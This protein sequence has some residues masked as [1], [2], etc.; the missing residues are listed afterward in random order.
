MSQPPTE[1]SIVVG[2][3]EAAQGFDALELARVG[4]E[5]LGG[6]V[7][8]VSV[9]ETD[10]LW[11]GAERDDADLVEH[12]AAVTRTAGRRLANVAYSVHVRF[13]RAAET[14]HEVAEADNAAAIVLG[15]SHRSSAGRALFGS[16]AEGVL[17]G[18][19]CP[20]AVA[21]P[22]YGR[23]TGNSLAGRIAV[24]YDAGQEARGAVHAAADVAAATGATL[25]I[26]GVLRPL[27]PSPG[28]GPY[29]PMARR[30]VQDRLDQIASE[31]RSGVTVETTLAEGDP[32]GCLA[33]AAAEADLLVV[34]SRGYGPVRRTLLGSVSR[35][36]IHKAS[37]PVLVMPK[38]WRASAAPVTDDE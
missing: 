37:A 20:V 38:A 15:S 22:D 8:V 19:P 28:R 29:L 18:A 2:F 17:Q 26:V 11:L 35:A 9:I 16:V 1:T 30:T 14:L 5:A 7:D 32:A 13:G 10:A 24:G 3:D 6:R 12:E 31:V 21:P 25:Q 33:G 34:G 23:R 36:V 4:V 27:Q